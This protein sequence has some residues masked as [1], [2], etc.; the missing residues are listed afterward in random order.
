MVQ[1]ALQFRSV[2]PKEDPGRLKVTLQ[3]NASHLAPGA[4]YE[5]WLGHQLSS[6]FMVSPGSSTQMPG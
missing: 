4:R 2:T 1:T 3:D 6:G 5:L